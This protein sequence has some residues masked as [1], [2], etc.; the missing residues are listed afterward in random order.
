MVL[1]NFLLL[2]LVSREASVKRE[3]YKDLSNLVSRKYKW[4]LQEEKLWP[5]RSAPTPSPVVFVVVVFACSPACHQSMVSPPVLKI[6]TCSKDEDISCAQGTPLVG[7]SEPARREASARCQWRAVCCGILSTVIIIIIIII[8]RR[9][10]IGIALNGVIQEARAQSCTNHLQ[11]I[12]RLLRGTCRVT[13][14]VVR[15]YSSAV[16]A[17]RV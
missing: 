7:S 4:S 10:I 8:R 12:E 17:D 1:S 15:R 5:P 14:H 2:P 6:R 13:C 9:M 3:N 16:K 11:H